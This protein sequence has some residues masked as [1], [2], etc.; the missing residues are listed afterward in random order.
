MQDQV[1]AGLNLLISQKNLVVGV[2]FCR[3]RQKTTL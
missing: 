2:A 1:M 3:R